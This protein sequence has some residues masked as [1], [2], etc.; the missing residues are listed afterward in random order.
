[1]VYDKAHTRHIPDLGGLAARM[2]IVA[3]GFLVAG[4]A[5]LGLPGTS[6]FVAEL[7]VFLGAFKVWSWITALAVF[8]IVITAGYIL[9][10]LQRAFFGPL[11]PR[12]ASIGDITECRVPLFD[13]GVES[14]NPMKIIW[15]TSDTSGLTD[16]GE[17]IV[18]IN[19]EDI[20]IEDVTLSLQ[21]DGP[22][23]GADNL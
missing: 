22:N 12:F 2:P 5:S 3:V 14:N 10:M 6:G 20:L 19:T 1:M 18:G 23:A 9:W 21:R 13:L 16:L 11:Q 8:A 7:L 15:Q 4:L 17:V